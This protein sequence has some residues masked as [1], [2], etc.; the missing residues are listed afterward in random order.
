MGCCVEGRG[1]AESQSLLPSPSRPFPLFSS[2]HS[3]RSPY[4]P[5]SL[6]HFPFSYLPRGI[7][8]QGTCL[9]AGI[10][11]L[12]L[13]EYCLWL[14]IRPKTRRRGGVGTMPQYTRAILSLNAVNGFKHNSRALNLKTRCC[15]S[16]VPF[17]PAFQ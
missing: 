10:H 7:S 16:Y 3:P 5:P 9:P 12:I 14:W 4:L 11:G 17:G 6:C 13:T 15:M 1:E 2:P 8:E